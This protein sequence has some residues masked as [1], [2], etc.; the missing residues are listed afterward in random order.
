VHDTDL[1]PR[2]YKHMEEFFAL[3]INTKIKYAYTNV[4]TGY[5]P[6][7][8]RIAPRRKKGNMVE[9]MY[10]KRDTGPRNITWHNGTQK[11]PKAP[12]EVRA[13]YQATMIEYAETLDDMANKYML[14]LYEHVLG[15]KPGFFK[16]GFGDGR[17]YLRL[18]TC[19]QPDVPHE[20]GQFSIAPHVDTSFVTILSR[21]EQ[22]PGLYVFT[23]QSEWKA[24]PQPPGC[25]TINNGQLLHQWTN[26]K[27]KASRHFAK[28]HGKG[29]RYSIPCFFHPHTEH[30]MDPADI[31][32]CC[33]PGEQPNFPAM[34]YMT[35]QAIAQGE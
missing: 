9:I 25:F 13:D 32:S 31:P 23:Y 8:T 29:D 20:E 11:W 6:V 30:V 1:L 14:P 2:M 7:G 5:V 19:H 35:S 26:G 15:L 3:D 24:V 12:E 33:P 4:G 27:A 10:Y 34:S 16:K 21:K 28:T 22:S 18:K 17:S